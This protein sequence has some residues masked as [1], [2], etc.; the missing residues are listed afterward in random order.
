MNKI[1]VLATRNEGKIQELDRMLRDQGI[2]VK[3]LKDYPDCP[4]VEEDGETFEQNAAK[5]A[6]TISKIIGLP[7]LADDSGLEV[8]A[9]DGEPGVYSARFAGPRATDEENIQ[10]LLER[11]KGIPTENRHARFRCALAY[12]APGRETWAC[13][14]R[15]EGI[16]SLEPQGNGGFGYDPIF[17]LP[18]LEKTMA[19]LTKSEKNEIS[20]RGKAVRQF[21]EA[22]PGLS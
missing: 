6:E 9:L 21:V 8:D 15:C 11:L 12:A 18:K 3:G 13:E 1:I 2:Q 5:K 7:T 16:I 22:L 19:Q 20:H 14:G 4:D 10:K 17:Y